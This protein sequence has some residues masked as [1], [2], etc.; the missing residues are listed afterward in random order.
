MLWVAI[1]IWRVFFTYYL[2]SCTRLLE[3]Q[4]EAALLSKVDSLVTVRRKLKVLI[5]MDGSVVHLER[6]IIHDI[7][8]CYVLSCKLDVVVDGIDVLHQL[9]LW[10]DDVISMA[11]INHIK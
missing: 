3:K 2:S 1:L 8:K 10:E 7:E 4:W 6:A 5:L 11:C 9:V